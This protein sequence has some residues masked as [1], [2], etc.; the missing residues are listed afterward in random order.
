MKVFVVT[1]AEFCC[2]IFCHVRWWMFIW[3]WTRYDSEPPNKLAFSQNLA[4][5]YLEQRAETWPLWLLR[6]RSLADSE[7]GLA[8][9]DLLLPVN[10]PFMERW[11]KKRMWQS[12]SGSLCFGMWRTAGWE[13]YPKTEKYLNK[14]HIC[15]G[16]GQLPLE[17]SPL[18]QPASLTVWTGTHCSLT[19]WSHK[20]SRWIL[21]QMVAILLSLLGKDSS[22]TAAQ[23]CCCCCAQ[24]EN[25]FKKCFFWCDVFSKMWFLSIML[26]FS[27]FSPPLQTFIV[28]NKGKAIF[29]FSA[30]S[31]L[32]IFTPFHLIRAIAIKI[33]VH[34]YPFWVLCMCLFL[35]LF[36]CWRLMCSSSP[37]T[38]EKGL[39]KPLKKRVFSLN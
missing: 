11:K 25:H 22:W 39:F 7:I 35:L 15:W 20:C 18:S 21:T 23:T 6:F 33:L 10:G 12:F 36:I 30:T 27:F 38:L 28:L 9:F 29:R 34:S 19:S 17:L 3:I 13:D 14:C 37:A 1:N 26:Y 5:G 8:S 31:A 2:Y 24:S 16:K 32:Y 4:S